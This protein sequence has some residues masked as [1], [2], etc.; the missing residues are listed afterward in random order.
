MSSHFDFEIELN[1]LVKLNAPIQSGPIP[2]W[3][4]KTLDHPCSS[5][6]ASSNTSP[7]RISNRSLS[8]SF[9]K[10]PG[11]F[12]PSSAKCKTP[13]QGRK[14]P[15]LALSLN[16][17]PSR[18][19]RYIPSR[20]ATNFELGQYKLTLENECLDEIE[21]VSKEEYKRALKENIKQFQ[22][23]SATESILAFKDK[24]AAAE[25]YQNSTK[26]LYSSSKKIN[27]NKKYRYIPS[28]PER[29]LDAPEM[30]DDFYLN[31]LDWSS[32]NTLAVALFESVYLYNANTGEIILLF[33]M[34]DPEDYICSLRWVPDGRYIAVGTSNAE[35]QL[36]DV[37]E[38][39]RLRV[40]TSHAAR[41]G[42]LC[43]NDH[44]L[45]SGSRDGFIHHHDVRIAEHLVRSN[46]GH[47]QEVCGLEWSPDK[48]LLAT[49]GNDNLINIWDDRDSQ[50]V[51]SFTDHQS[52]VK[53]MAWCPWQPNV[54][55]TGGGSADRHIRFWNA[56]NGSLIN[57]VD[58]KSQV[59]A[60][61][62]STHHKEIISSHGFSQ[63]QLT[64]WSYPSMR[65]VQ[66]LLGHRT[67][68]L[69]LAMSPDGT[70]ICS[71][72][73]DETLRMWNCF[74]LD[75]QQKKKSDLQSER[76]QKLKSKVAPFMSIR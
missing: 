25:G 76:E 31:L 9:K 17:T 39:K 6:N 19:D 67:R 54:L 71:G 5:L 60:L 49:G 44:I 41:V 69:Y 75:D 10:T 4:R 48:K 72:A 73:P 12:T 47:T 24:P 26:V 11:T 15:K 68:V 70:T 28:Q 63:Y 62:W 23:N 58:T 53:A 50:P 64:I 16:T 2:R 40:L 32:T 55:A 33:S 65:R 37:T 36:W 66:D 21:T 45:S 18:N 29:V 46:Q 14:T 59:C 3:Q 57:A 52:A 7:L 43:W 74:A 22:S 20:Q 34:E 51:Y 1:N 38:S 30:L 56:F 42:S 27:V 35:I 13:G 8:S 61:K